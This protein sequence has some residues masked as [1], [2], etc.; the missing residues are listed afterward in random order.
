VIPLSPA[1][2]QDRSPSPAYG[3]GFAGQADAQSEWARCRLFIVAAID[4]SLGLQSIEDVERLIAEGVYQ[5]WPAARSA[6]I[7][8]IILFQQTKVLMVRI[9]GGDLSELIEMEKTFCKFA[10]AN[11][12]KKIMGEGRLGWQRVS[13]RMGYQ[14]GFVTMAKDLT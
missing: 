8:E 3:R 10:R 7:T 6:V 2:D 5:F 11:G 1:Y 4:Q 13:E 14:F 9:G 12:C